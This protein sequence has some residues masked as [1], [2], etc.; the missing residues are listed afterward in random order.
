MLRRYELAQVKPRGTGDLVVIFFEVREEFLFELGELFVKLLLGGRLSRFGDFD[1]LGFLEKEN[2]G[3]VFLG[4]F[5]DLQ[6]GLIAPVQFLAFFE[7]SSVGTAAD[8]E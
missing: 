1:V 7:L 2:A 5:H 3:L 6:Q 4:E 8:L